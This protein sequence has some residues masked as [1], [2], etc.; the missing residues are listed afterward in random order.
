MRSGSAPT[1]T[2]VV[3][4]ATALGIDAEEARS[5]AGFGDSP[6]RPAAGGAKRRS[7]GTP[8]RKDG[9]RKRYRTDADLTALGRELRV[10]VAQQGLT[11]T[12]L[13]Q[14]HDMHAKSWTR[15]LYDT[16]NCRTSTILRAAD[17]VGMAHERALELSGRLGPAVAPARPSGPDAARSF[18]GPGAPGS[19]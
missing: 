9:D 5:A 19:P 1:L 17:M 13:C 8:R 18:P 15:V 14:S 12:A 3:T 11:E 10:L 7:T 6:T 4:F 2:T 16:A